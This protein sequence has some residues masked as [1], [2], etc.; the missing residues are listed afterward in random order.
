MIEVFTR[1]VNDNPSDNQTQNSQSV[2]FPDLPTALS[3]MDF[4][5]LSIPARGDGGQSDTQI[6]S[7]TNTISVVPEPASF[8]RAAALLVGLGVGRCGRERIAAWVGPKRGGVQFL[9]A[10]MGDL[11][12]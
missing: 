8:A 2:T 6:T 1:A 5:T 7:V 11:Q 9:G 4:A 10:Q 3:V 12:S